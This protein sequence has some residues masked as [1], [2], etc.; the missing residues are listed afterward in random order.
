VS[1]GN[2]IA[3]FPSTVGPDASSSRTPITPLNTAYE[4]RDLRRAYARLRA[5]AT[6]T[7]SGNAGAAV[8]NIASLAGAARVLSP[9]EL[10][11]ILVAQSYTALLIRVFAPQT[12][13][14][15][16]RLG[17]E[18]AENASAR[19]VRSLVVTAALLDVVTSIATL[20]IGFSL[21]GLV[22]R[23]GGW[24]PPTTEAASVYL[25]TG[26]GGVAGTA[27]GVLR[28]YD[29][30]SL[31]AAYRIIG[32]A[33]KCIG[34]ITIARGAAATNQFLICWV[35]AELCAAVVVSAL[36]G[37]ELWSRSI[38]QRG[39][40]ITFSK[41]LV[42][43]ALITGAHTTIKS[44]TKDLDVLIVNGVGGSSGAAIYKLARQLAS[45][46]N[47]LTDPVAQ[48]VVPE[49]T[50]LAVRRDWTSFGLLVRQCLGWGLATGLTLLGF[51]CTA[52]EPLLRYIGT[53]SYEQ[54]L[55]VL[56]F[57]MA[58]NAVA[59]TFFVLQPA[60]VAMGKPEL[61]LRSLSVATLCYVAAIYPLSSRYG[62][63]G[64]AVAYL[65][66][67]CVWAI[68]L[69]IALNGALKA[70]SRERPISFATA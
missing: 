18:Q 39:R 32:P 20:V 61:G 69:S 7:L 62:M 21:L 40:Q 59:L 56:V 48:A 60:T 57:S 68:A 49:L 34:A 33:L 64:P 46:V 11:V 53:E 8:L 43:F 35:G 63:T 29:R 15:I 27:V 10:G 51:C 25:I 41:P 52:G 12:P 2:T 28:L 24:N 38:L 4:R 14:A 37:R 19:D 42:R 44:V 6:I 45:G 30:F 17:T 65:L 3:P 47:Q 55:A 66:F 54:G 67:Y 70:Q 26:L 50:K 23:V 58:A 5:N 16:L 13:F 1:T 36:A 9:A 22:V 31:L